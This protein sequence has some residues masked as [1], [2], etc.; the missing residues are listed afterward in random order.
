V[1]ACRVQNH[2]PACSRTS[3]NHVLVE[4]HLCADVTHLGRRGSAQAGAL[5][6]VWYEDLGVTLRAITACRVCSNACA[7]SSWNTSR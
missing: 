6:A 2:P 3:P 7:I 5:M 4:T 1:L